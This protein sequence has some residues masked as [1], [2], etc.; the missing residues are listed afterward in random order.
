MP[1]PEAAPCPTCRVQVTTDKTLRPKEF[2]FCS[3]R[4]QMVDLHK[5]ITGE[6]RVP[7]ESAVAF[8]PD[9]DH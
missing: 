6:Y 8:A 9:D 7:G 3:S 4:C 2:P 5:W 1:V